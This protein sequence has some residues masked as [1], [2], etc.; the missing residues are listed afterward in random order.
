MES[1]AD[2]VIYQIYVLNLDRVRV[3]LIHHDFEGGGRKDCRN[4]YRSIQ[5]QT[6]SDSLSFL[7]SVRATTS[8]DRRTARRRLTG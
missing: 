6:V 2:L 5:N 8:P 1:S 4:D 3:Q 7:A